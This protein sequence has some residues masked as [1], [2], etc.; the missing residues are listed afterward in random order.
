[1]Y[2]NL[3]IAGTLY[4][5]VKS[6]T[7]APEFDPTCASLPICEFEAEFRTSTPASDFMDRTAGIVPDYNGNNARDTADEIIVGGYN[8]EEAKQTGADMVYIRARSWLSWLD[9]RVLAAELFSNVNLETFLFRLFKDMPVNEG[10]PVWADDEDNPPIQIY[11]S[12]NYPV[13]TGYCPEQ[14]A[15]ERLQWL[16]QAR[17]FQISQWDSL[18]SNGLL[19]RYAPD[20]P[21]ANPS[22]V[23]IR[24]EYTYSKPVIRQITPVGAVTITSCSDFTTTFHDEAGWDSV[25][26]GYDYELAED[27]VIPIEKRLYFRKQT[28][29][30]DNTVFGEAVI[31]E[32]NTLL[33]GNIASELNAMPAPYFRGYEVEL[34]CLQLWPVGH[35]VE[36]YFPGTRVRFYTDPQT[37]YTGI[38]K[39]ASFTFGLLAKAKLVISTDQVPVEMAHVIVRDVYAPSSGVERLLCTRHYWVPRDAGSYTVYNT[40][41]REYV[42][43]R[44]ERFT[45]SA[46]STAISTSGAEQ[47]VTVVYTRA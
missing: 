14:T 34:E 7:C 41:M 12:V 17:M 26:T 4:T 28:H 24:P 6:I 23:T 36:Y 44:L 39:S 45:P 30:T 35:S 3:L 32:D 37:M 42:G 21:N 16:C 47:T 25:V 10:A 43:D 19:L 18:S 31:V 5:D 11:G 15:R 29:R 22:Y 2:Y 1:M 40:Q 9:K 46:S 8:I 27:G 33:L 38:V 13:V 20:H